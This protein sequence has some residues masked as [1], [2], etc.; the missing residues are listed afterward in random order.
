MNNQ[1]N[2]DANRYFIYARKSSE[3]EDR[4]MASID[5]QIDELTKLAQE[6]NLKVV[7]VFSE[8]KS[9]KAPGR[10]I[11][12]DMMQRIKKGEA[13]GIIC[14]KL[15]RLARNP[16]DGGEV[17]WMLQQN[18][19]KHIFT[20]GRSYYPT[21]NVIVMA[22]ELGMANQFVRDLSVDAKRGLR[23][24][25][26]RGWYPSF[27]TLGYI[28][29]PLKKKGG[30]EITKDEERFPLVRRMFDLMLSG[31]YT[32]PKILAIAT[33]DWG[34]RMKNNGK[35]ARSTIYRIFSDPFYYGEFEYPKKS[36]NWYQGQH[37]AMIKREEYDRIQEL[38]GKKGNPRLRTYTFAFTGMIRCGECGCLITAENKTKHQKNGNVHNYIYYHCTKRR[39]YC[40]QKT[41]RDNDLEN[42]IKKEL[43]VI[44][45]S[46]EF[47]ELAMEIIQKENTREFSDKKT[48]I[49][50][51]QKAY[52]SCV[53][54]YDGL[55]TM[56]A[57]EQIDEETFLRKK[58]ILEQERKRLRG[59]LDETDKS[60][61]DWLER[62]EQLFHFAEI[63]KFRFETGTIQDKKE[64]L[65]FLGSNLLLKDQKLFITK[66]NE[67]IT[68]E[69]LAKEEKAIRNRLEPLSFGSDKTR[70]WAEYTQS[71]MMLRR[72]DS[73]L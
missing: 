12:A 23:S 33:N 55:V 51:Q 60:V 15:N 25:A 28:H 31:N 39:G 26:D 69:E 20:Y 11:F 46:P 22:V 73:N 72:Q 67:L 1:Q 68:M 21:D 40:N 36:G 3:S 71:P 9:A 5:S 63:G 56:R 57:K 45:I 50:S 14:W 7:K 35:M 52:T 66:K 59:L 10:P 62:A 58:V 37:E 2:N 29:N 34:L 48:I 16:I 24:K 27:S 53:A 44:S 13:D 6:N 32:P 8:S 54:E 70:L 64:V 4:Q 47:K 41:I 38:L 17:S 18:I 49:S 30:K 61:D 65:S 42:Q 43:D 19:V